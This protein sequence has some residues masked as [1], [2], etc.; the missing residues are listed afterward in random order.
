MTSFERDFQPSESHSYQGSRIDD[1]FNRVHKESPKTDEGVNSNES[2]KLQDSK[3]FDDSPSL[4]ASSKLDLPVNI[5]VDSFENVA[6][7]YNK[8]KLDSEA[9]ATNLMRALSELS[10]QQL[11]AAGD[12]L[13]MKDPNWSVTRTLNEKKELESTFKY[14]YPSAAASLN[15]IK[16]IAGGVDYAVHSAKNYAIGPDLEVKLAGSKLS[17][18]SNDLSRIFKD[19][20]FNTYSEIHKNWESGGSFKRNFY[21]K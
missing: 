5:A 16:M 4:S 12:E 15:P 10:A 17:V 18:E 21:A 9:A 7:N 19:G 14:T 13:L 2:P 3:N 11:T 20:T 1:L 8:G 6:A